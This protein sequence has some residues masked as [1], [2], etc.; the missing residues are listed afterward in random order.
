MKIYAFSDTHLNE[1]AVKK[2]KKEAKRAD[3]LICCGDVSWY[4]QGLEKILKD[5]NKINK[6]IYIIPG[7]H[8][9]PA[10]KMRKICQRLENIHYMHKRTKIINGYKFFFWGGG[11]FA[12][13]NKNFE[14]AA[15]QFKSR[16]KKD[17]EVVLI[18]HGPPY[19]TKLD[20]L[21][22]AGHVGCKSIRKFIKQIKPILF[23]CGHLHENFGVSETL[24]KT[25]FAISPGPAGKMIEL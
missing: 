12:E 14:K 11:G 17:E 19:N 5:L 6:T 20:Y 25:T 18:T 8:E 23:I 22:W 1:K 2:I 16:L 24:F 4:G 3:F 15:K 10:T 7:N 9:E 21:E 13:V